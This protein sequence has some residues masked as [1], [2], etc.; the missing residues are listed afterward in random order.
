VAYALNGQAVT[1]FDMG[2]H[3]D[4]L[5]RAQEAIAI[6]SEKL[7]PDNHENVQPLMISGEAQLQLGDAR[8]AVKTL[9][10]AM[11]IVEANPG[12]PM[13]LASVRIALAE[14]LQKSG[15]NERARG[16]LTQA[17][18]DLVNRADEPRAGDMIK[19]IDASLAK[20]PRPR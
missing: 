18:K 8:A 12:D 6:W 2:R 15:E 9:E 14:A 11:A 4:A 7:G 17:R 13:N 1:L 10:R 5:A 3:R 20:L 19:D 16:L